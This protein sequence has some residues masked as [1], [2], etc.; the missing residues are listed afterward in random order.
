MAGQ[1]VLINGRWQD[2]AG[3]RTFQPVNPATKQPLGAEYPVSPWSEVDAVLRAADDAFAQIRGV[4]GDRFAGFL[5]DFADAI[6]R[7]T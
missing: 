4:A 1:P 7:H 3:S 5:A 2:S 6:E